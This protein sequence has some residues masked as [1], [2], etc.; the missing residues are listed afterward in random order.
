MF[1]PLTFKYLH[2]IQAA[3]TFG[4]EKLKKD[5]MLY[6]EGHTLDVLKRTS[7][8]EMSAPTL[9]YILQSDKLNIDELEV[10]RIIRD[11]STVNAVSLYSISNKVNL[12]FTCWLSK[13]YGLISSRDTKPLVEHNSATEAVGA[14]RN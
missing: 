1:Y 5:L 12:R 9:T 7:I 14:S 2:Y 4:L 11:W 13:R 3:V 10:Y 8:I 6:F